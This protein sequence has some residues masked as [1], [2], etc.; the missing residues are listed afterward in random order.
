MLTRCKDLRYSHCEQ[1]VR[2]VQHD[3]QTR[4]FD[5]NGYLALTRK[6]GEQGEL[7][8]YEQHFQEGLGVRLRRRVFQ[9]KDSRTLMRGAERA[10]REDRIGD[11]SAATLPGV[12]GRVEPFDDAGRAHAAER[13]H[14]IKVPVED[15]SA[16]YGIS[17]LQYSTSGIMIPYVVLPY[18]LT[19]QYNRKAMAP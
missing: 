5:A 6:L 4:P 1:R 8:S 17:T 2:T 19:V 10:E 18:G 12:R 16:R 14:Q 13:R 7:P 15:F 9:L 11:L 3:L